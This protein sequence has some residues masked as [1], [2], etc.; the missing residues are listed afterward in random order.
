VAPGVQV[1]AKQ[2]QMDAN[3]AGVQQL[4]AAPPAI[5]RALSTTAAATVAR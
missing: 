1:Q 2:V 5:A 4:V 3:N